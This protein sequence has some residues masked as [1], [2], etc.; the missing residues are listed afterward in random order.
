MVTDDHGRFL[1]SLAH[2]ILHV[3]LH[4][5]HTMDDKVGH[6]LQKSVIPQF[7]LFRILTDMEIQPRE[8]KHEQIHHQQEEDDGEQRTEEASQG[9][10]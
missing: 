4:P 6:L 2:P 7:L 10:G 8:R 1:E 5:R 3:E 9:D